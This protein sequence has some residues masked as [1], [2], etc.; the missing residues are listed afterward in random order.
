MGLFSTTKKIYVDSSLFNLAGEQ[1][2]RA[3][4]LKSVV[5]HKTILGGKETYGSAIQRSLMTGPGIGLRRY[6]AWTQ[7]PTNYGLI[8][9]PSARLGGDIDLNS[10]LVAAQ[11]PHDPDQSI[12]IQKLEFGVADFAWWAEQWMLAND[13]TLLDQ[14][15][16]IDRDELTGEIVIVVGE[17]EVVQFLPANFLRDNLYI[18][19]G[20]NRATGAIAG[21]VVP[22]DVITLGP[23]DSFPS[24][25]GWQPIFSSSTRQNF[26]LNTTSTR[27]VTLSTG[28]PPKVWN[29]SSQRVEHRE[30]FEALYRLRQYQGVDPGAGDGLWEITSNRYLN[31]DYVIDPV[32]TITSVDRL[33]ADGTTTETTHTVTVVDTL[34]AVKTHR[35]DVQ[36]N[37]VA[38]WGPL[39]IFI[40]RL[41]SGNSVLDGLVRDELDENE[42]EYL[43]FIP[44]RINNRSIDHPTTAAAY[45]QAS[46]AY[47][48]LT[49]GG[50]LRE[51]LDKIEDND[52]IAD[53]DY[54]YITHAV[55]LNVSHMAG[56]RYLYTYFQRLMLGQSSDELK[57][58]FWSQ[59]A[60][61]QVDG[62]ENWF[63]W[64]L[65]QLNSANTFYGRAE[66]FQ[67]TYTPQPQNTVRITNP[68]TG[69]DS[70]FD[71]V[72]S[73]GAISEETGTG[74]ANPNR[75]VGDLWWENE[76]LPDLSLEVYNAYQSFPA[77]I[78][79]PGRRLYWQKTANEWG[80]LTLEN[81][82]HKNYI[83]GG[84]FVEI[85]MDTA[86]ADPEESGFL[87][88]LHY[89]TYRS[90]SLVDST[91]IA[92]ECAFLVL[93]TYL[94]KKIKW[95]QK[96]WFK[97]FLIVV[98][99][100]ITVATGGIGAST[101][102]LLGTNIAVGTA[103]GLTGSLAVIAGIVVNTL[104]SMVLM[105]IIQRGAIE[106]FGDKVGAILGAIVAV[107]ALGAVTSLSNGGNLATM[108]SSLTSAQGL[109][110]LTDAVG[111]GVAGAMTAGTRDIL[112]RTQDVVEQFEA[113]SQKLT[114]LY[115]TNIGYDNGVFD[116]M[117]L[118][119]AGRILIEGPEGFLT[120]TLMT[121]SDIAEAT[122]S[123]LSEFATLTLSTDLPIR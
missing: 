102:G 58:Q 67:S 55:P 34:R 4:F 74:L 97:V 60:N 122:H 78:K 53:I 56:R 33:L 82:V 8:G 100:A 52:Q 63:A 108:W 31:T 64:K 70:D 2:E 38:S 81:L 49:G 57:Y 93:N 106:V 32:E 77:T 99:I 54:A 29:S 90:L 114:E 15:F 113:E 50:K 3:N 59:I 66:P 16:E 44:C 26:T 76:S 14:D 7:N 121:G 120:R 85:S 65:G 45:A 91:Q 19:A 13:P 61:S 116:P 109:I 73:W 20:F 95:Y 25:V 69:L 62:N 30:V 107:V 22:G 12:R 71:M 47:K 118:T 28:E 24:V 6:F 1:E 48:K 27:T 92:N 94:V 51:F 68:S 105:A 115:A 86:L 43:P 40:Y 79:R 89:P 18:Y 37:T 39:E 96:G 111:Q 35:T 10:D 110:S 104:A 11:I 42:G 75:K 72:M 98:I 117:S 46:K 17:V 5:T 9:V 41:G 123:L 103:I 80:C 36:E 112:D 23:S 119:D 84:K 101:A 87:V 83:Y 88:P 21:E